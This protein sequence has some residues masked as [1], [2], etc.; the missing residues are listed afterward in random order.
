MTE[1]MIPWLY[2]PQNTLDTRNGFRAIVN[3]E[4]KS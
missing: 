1:F 2:Y 3:T 4:E